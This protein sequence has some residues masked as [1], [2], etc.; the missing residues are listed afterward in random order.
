MQNQEPMRL[1]IEHY[2]IDI[3]R[4]YKSMKACIRGHWQLEGIL[5]HS[6][7]NLDNLLQKLGLCYG[8]YSPF[9]LFVHPSSDYTTENVA[10]YVVA[11]KDNCY[12]QEDHECFDR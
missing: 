2:L 11:M 7:E 12:D 1:H 10:K 5:T 3:L 4:E 9:K 8:E 6:D